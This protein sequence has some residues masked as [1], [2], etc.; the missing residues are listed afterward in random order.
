MLMTSRAKKKAVIA[1]TGLRSTAE[2]SKDLIFIKEMIEEG[3]LRPV[4]DRKYQLA[5][6]VEAHKYVDQGHKKGSVI[7]SLIQD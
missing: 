2:R 5:D 6:I 1:F 4:I 3:K 7:I